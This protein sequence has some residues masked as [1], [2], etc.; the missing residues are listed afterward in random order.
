MTVFM[1]I[2]SKAV[3]PKPV[4]EDPPAL[5]ILY[6][7]LIR[8]TQL[9]LAVSTNELMSVISVFDKGD[10]QKVQ[11]RGAS[12]TGLGSTG[13]KHLKRLVKYFI[14]LFIIFLHKS[15]HISAISAVSSIRPSSQ[16]CLI[17]GHS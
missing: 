10:I 8:H 17:S 13:L 16:Q 7:S 2:L 1:L 9:V 6:F 11:G 3:L 12:R 4:L 14:Y 15:K 5:H